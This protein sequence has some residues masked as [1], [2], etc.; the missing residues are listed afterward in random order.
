VLVWGGGTGPPRP[1]GTVELWSGERDE[2][3]DELM[4]Q[5]MAL[6]RMTGCPMP[7]HTFALMLGRKKERVGPRPEGHDAWSVTQDVCTATYSPEA[8]P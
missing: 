7:L 1:E 2:E 8:E 4:I 5:I 3:Y 6:E